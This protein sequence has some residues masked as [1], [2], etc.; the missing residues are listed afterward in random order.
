MHHLPPDK[1]EMLNNKPRT[2]IAPHTPTPLSQLTTGN[3][4][5]MPSHSIKV[6]YLS[7]C[8]KQQPD[9]SLCLIKTVKRTTHVASGHMFC[10]WYV[11][12]VTLRD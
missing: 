11:T 3:V 4:L 9:S 6:Q 5:I 8:G 12:Q 1:V 7:V 10:L 2:H